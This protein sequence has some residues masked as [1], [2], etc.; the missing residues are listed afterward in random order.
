MAIEAAKQLNEDS[1]DIAG[2]VLRDVHI[3]G[4]IDLSAN[5]GNAEVQ[6]SLRDTQTARPSGP[7]YEFAVRTFINEKWL[8]NCRGLILVE[9]SER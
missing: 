4:P 9:L 2:Y 3:E 1:N 7:T 8:L 5:A 6:T